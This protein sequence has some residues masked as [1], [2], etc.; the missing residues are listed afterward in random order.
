MC[1]VLKIN[2]CLIWPECTLIW[3][4]G[5]DIGASWHDPYKEKKNYYAFTRLF[6]HVY[7]DSGYNFVHKVGMKMR[8]FFFNM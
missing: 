5:C 6:I 3:V 8:A 4:D 7:N 1:N 2:I